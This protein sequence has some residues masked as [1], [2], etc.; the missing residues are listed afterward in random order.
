M[1]W[2][3]IKDKMPKKD[4]NVIVCGYQESGDTELLTFYNTAW[5]NGFGW[6]DEKGNFGDGEEILF[7][8]PLPLPPEK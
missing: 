3:N 4:E 1:E 2:I 8:M 5:Y 6:E 7:W